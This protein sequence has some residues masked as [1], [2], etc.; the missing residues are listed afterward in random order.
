MKG[1][2]SQ[3]L[4]IFK[5]KLPVQQQGKLGS[6]PSSSAFQHAA[7]EAQLSPS[8]GLPIYR[9]GDKRRAIWDK[10]VG[11]LLDPGTTEPTVRVMG[12]WGVGRWESG[13]LG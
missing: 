5:G 8:L 9:E 2:P 3:S 7:L 11:V 4:L 1:V 12:R 13:Q 6:H 10:L